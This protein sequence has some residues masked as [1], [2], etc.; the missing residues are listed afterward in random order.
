MV[1]AC[2]PAVQA[3][4]GDAGEHVQPGRPDILADVDYAAVVGLLPEEP[5]TIVPSWYQEG[6][7]AE[8]RRSQVPAPHHAGFGRCIRREWLY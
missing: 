5:G 1:R 8:L 4:D 7:G 3:D 2:R 6:Y